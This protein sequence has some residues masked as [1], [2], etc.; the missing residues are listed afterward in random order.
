MGGQISTTSLQNKNWAKCGLAAEIHL[1]NN[2]LEVLHNKT[3]DPSYVGLPED[4][5]DLYMFFQ[6]INIS[7][8]KKKTFFPDQLDIVL[9]QQ[10]DQVDS[11][12]CDITLITGLIKAFIAGYPFILA[13]DE[14]RVF[15]NNLKHGT[16]DD[17]KTEQQLQTKLGEMRSLL[18]RMKYTKLQEFEDMVKDDKFLIDMNEGLNHLTNVMNELEKD[19]KDDFG[20][21]IEHAMKNLFAE[22]TNKLKPLLNGIV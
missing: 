6:K 21:K 1:R 8:K 3:N 19:L 5:K 2:L 17:F 22:I 15:R 14:A 16:L 18:T 11:K 4:P 13:I 20:D 9:P 7:N 10:G 12:E